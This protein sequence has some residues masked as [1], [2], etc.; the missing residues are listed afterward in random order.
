MERSKE[1]LKVIQV[2]LE[3]TFR[4]SVHN[5]LELLKLDARKKDV[6]VY[7]CVC[8]L[9][10]SHCKYRLARGKKLSPQEFSY[11]LIQAITAWL[12]SIIAST[13]LDAH[14]LSSGATILYSETS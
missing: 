11:K 3:N 9:L 12:I 5:S 2:L 8:M 4:L 6:F 7:K 1:N 14:L 13:R 10:I